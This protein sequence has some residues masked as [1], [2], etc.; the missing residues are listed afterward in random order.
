MRNRDEDELSD[1]LIDDD[2]EEK[3]TK[4]RSKKIF[5]IV[6]MAVILLLVVVFAIYAL[7]RE[8]T[9]KQPQSPL[10]PAPIQ[11]T[12]LPSDSLQPSASAVPSKDK[13]ED[14]IAR[15]KNEQPK[16]EIPA[17][18]SSQQPTTIAPPPG[19]GNNDDLQSLFKPQN[20]APAPAPAPTPTPPAAQT[21]APAPTPPPAAPKQT[22]ATNEAPKP[23]APPKVV[24]IASDPNGSFFIQ[25]A[26]VSRFSEDSNFAK[27]I[28]SHKLPYRVQE[29][30][31]NN[32]TVYRVLIGPYGS[33]ADAQ[34]VLSTVRY[35]LEKEAFIKQVN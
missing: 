14:I 34:K 29:E 35:Y 11:N 26:S 8:E 20:P 4:G 1:I 25:A 22:T 33:K 24:D 5:L 27:K 3:E 7:T 12:G 28:K 23:A 21:P 16:P 18:P 19:V 13:F 32:K 6:A 9:P 30:N 17:K 15:I 2:E 10:A 31:V